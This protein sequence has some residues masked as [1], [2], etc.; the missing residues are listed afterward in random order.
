MAL[1]LSKRYPRIPKDTNFSL[2]VDDG[3]FEFL[4]AA[5]FTI[6]ITYIKLKVTVNYIK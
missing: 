2:K 1:L 4:E 5:I 3:D 6:I